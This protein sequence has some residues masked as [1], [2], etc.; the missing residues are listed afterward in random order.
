MLE[1]TQIQ[2]LVEIVCEKGLK[3][4]Q[5]NL[6]CGFVTFCLST[7][8]MFW[9]PGMRQKKQGG[10]MNGAAMGGVQSPAQMC[11]ARG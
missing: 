4:A 3:L 5:D 7:I 11:W 1:V 10:P 9:S 6:D 8:A 2:R